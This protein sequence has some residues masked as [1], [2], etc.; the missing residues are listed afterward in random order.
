[1]SPVVPEQ[2]QMS[3]LNVST[4][5]ESLRLRHVSGLLLDLYMIFVSVGDFFFLDCVCT[6]V[7][8]TFVSAE[9]TFSCFL[10]MYPSHWRLWC[11]L[12]CAE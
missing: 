8:I 1:M 5:V 7:G 12:Y 4:M 2:E 11:S 10:S 6:V 9:M 3:F